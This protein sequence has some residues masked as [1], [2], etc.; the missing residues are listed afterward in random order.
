MFLQALFG[1]SHDETRAM[2]DVNKLLNL[3][4]SR[5][6]ELNHDAK[7]NISGAGVFGPIR[8]PVVIRRITPRTAADHTAAAFVRP[9]WVLSRCRGFSFLPKIVAPLPH[10]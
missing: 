10:I 9:L 1:K 2:T 5:R 4:V 8:A 6:V 3:N 7:P